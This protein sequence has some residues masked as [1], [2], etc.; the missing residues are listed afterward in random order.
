[1][2]THQIK[3]KNNS[4]IYIRE[5]KQKKV[6]TAW[7]IGIMYNKKPSDINTILKHNTRN[8][9]E[10]YDYFKIPRKEFLENFK[11]FQYTIPNNNKNINL[12][13]ATGFLKIV[14]AFQIKHNYK[15]L[16]KMYE[17]LDG[18]DNINLY[19]TNIPKEIYFKESLFEAFKILNIKIIHQFQIDVYRVDFY[20]PE[21]NIVIEYDEEHHR[22]NYFKDK[23][24]EKI[25]TEKL[26]CVFIRCNAQD[27]DIKNIIKILNHIFTFKHKIP[28]RPKI[29]EEQSDEFIV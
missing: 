15:K 27:S 19:I 16:Q 18:K 7:D 10:G 28:I 26:N 13:T 9:T 21:H 8:F 2:I 24:R 20:I 4:K 25:I 22:N 23:L 29:L 3:K 14:K 17:K 11:N 1:M 12:F 5:Y 6:I